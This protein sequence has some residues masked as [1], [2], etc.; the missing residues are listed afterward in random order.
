MMNNFETCFLFQFS[1]HIC[2]TAKIRIN[3]FFAFDAND[4]RMRI[5]FVAIVPIAPFGESQ[6]Q[7]LVEFFE[8][9]NCFIHSSKACGWKIRFDLFIDSFHG[10]VFNAANQNLQNRNS[11]RGDSELMR[12]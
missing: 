3:D 2:Q 1:G 5:W 8:E 4:M 12:S 10:W 6:F 9:G 11:L 7:N